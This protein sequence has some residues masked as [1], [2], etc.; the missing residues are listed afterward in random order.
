MSELTRKRRGPVA[1]TAA[2]DEQL[3]HTDLSPLQSATAVAVV[4]GNAKDAADALL[5][6]A[7]LGLVPGP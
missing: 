4:C 2:V 6:L 1:E 7:V 5:L 3:A